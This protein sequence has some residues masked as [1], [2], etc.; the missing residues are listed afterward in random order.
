MDEASRSPASARA[1]G[2]ARPRARHRQLRGIGPWSA[3]ITIPDGAPGG[4]S[5][6]PVGG[7]LA[8]AVAGRGQAPARA[9]GCAAASSPLSAAW[10]PWRSVRS[11]ARSDALLILTT[12]RGGELYESTLMDTEGQPPSGRGD[13]RRGESTLYDGRQG[14]LAATPY[15]LQRPLRARPGAIRGTARRR[16][17]RLLHHGSSAHALGHDAR[18]HA[19]AHRDPGDGHA[20]EARRRLHVTEGASRRRHPRRRAADPAKV[21]AAARGAKASCPLSRA[22]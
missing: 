4:P 18:H 14:A 21:E 11:A 22:C 15:S 10:A 5:V 6:W 12:R 9:A 1:D 8:L 16:A 19:R 7:D 13:L 17:C 3:D 20:R 2:I